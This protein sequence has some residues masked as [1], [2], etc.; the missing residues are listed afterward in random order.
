MIDSIGA[1][2][3]GTY[4]TISHRVAAGYLRFLVKYAPGAG[5]PQDDQAQG[6]QDLHGFF[7]AFYE[8]LYR[9]PDLFGLPLGEDDWIEEDEPHE[10]EKKQ[11]VTARLKKPKEMLT[12]ALDFLIGAGVQGRLVGE[13]LVLDQ[14]ADLVKQARVA[15]KF[16]AGLESAGLAVTPEK[17]GLTLQNSQFPGML[18]ALQELANACTRF[19]RQQENQFHFARCD[20]GALQPGYGPQPMDL[21]RDFAGADL[22]R[23]TA[24]HEFFTGLGYH[25]TGGISEPFFWIVQYQGDRKIKSTP[26]FQVEYQ[27]RY[28]KPVRVSIKCASTGRLA[29][30]LPYQ[31]Q[32]LQDDFI[33]RANLCQKCDWCRNNKTLGPTVVQYKG[34]DK[35]LC[36]YTAPEVRWFDDRSVELIEEYAQMHAALLPA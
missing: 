8:N 11:A 14:G 20:F 35:T 18:P 17:D 27:D 3:R 21:Y 16:L 6:R 5:Q 13:R 28:R 33:R 15:R 9:Q 7:K 29:G 1:G 32:A 19:P 31:S 30:L 23:L 2:N 36:W 10:K 25:T 12:R 4:P 22:P 24:L 34:E 26:F